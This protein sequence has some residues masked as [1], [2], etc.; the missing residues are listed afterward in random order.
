MSDPI[1]AAQRSRV[2]ALFVNLA[3]THILTGSFNQAHKILDSLLQ[4]MYDNEATSAL[5][6]FKPE[7]DV[8]FAHHLLSVFL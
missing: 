1:D 7:R 6:D 2:K 3:V 8:L 4:K 5:L